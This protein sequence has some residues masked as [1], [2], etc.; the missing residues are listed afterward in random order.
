MRDLDL[1]WWVYAAILLVLG[2]VYGIVAANIPDSKAVH[3]AEAFGITDVKVESSSIIA[4]EFRGCS[5]SDEKMWTVSGTN[6]QGQK[7]HLLVCAGVLKGA[8][9]RVK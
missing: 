6:S 7:V 3:A 9:V 1:P 2:V 5:D 4:V 8:T